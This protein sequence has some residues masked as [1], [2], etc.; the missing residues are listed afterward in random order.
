MKLSTGEIVTGDIIIGA[1]GPRSMV[2]EV[3]LGEEDQPRPSGITALS[4]IVPASELA[5]DPELYELVTAEKVGAGLRA[6]NNTA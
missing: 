6:R 4:G 1:D 2:R 5:K 3:V